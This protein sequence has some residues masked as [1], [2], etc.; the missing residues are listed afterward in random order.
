DVTAHRAARARFGDDTADRAVTVEADGDVFEVFIR[1]TQ[2][3]GPAQSP[4]ERG[5]GRGSGIVSV[6]CLGD[7]VGR[8]GR[9]QTD[10]GVRGGGLNQMVVSIFQ[11]FLHGNMGLIGLM[12]LMGL[13]SFINPISLIS[14]ISPIS[15]IMPASRLSYRRVPSRAQQHPIAF[16]RAMRVEFL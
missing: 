9:D 12:G 6:A 3:Q 11:R 4:S 7:E 2:Q 16:W 10:R 15:L 13:I 8:D 5:R 14:L 1:V